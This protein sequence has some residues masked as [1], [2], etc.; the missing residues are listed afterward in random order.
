V[1]TLE[2]VGAGLAR[3]RRVAG[4]EAAPLQGESILYDP[5]SKRFFVL[6]R[7]A[8]FVWER[9]ESPAVVEDLAAAVCGAFQAVELEAARSDVRGTLVQMVE[10]GLVEPVGATHEKEAK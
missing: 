7:T 3:Y 10:L 5:E 9:L 6:N 2:G 1:T 4:V 8:A